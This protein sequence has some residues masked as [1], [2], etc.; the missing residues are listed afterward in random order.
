M[1]SV[2]YFSGKIVRK[3]KEKKDQMAKH[4]KSGAVSGQW[5]AHV[6]KAHKKL[7]AG[8]EYSLLLPKMTKAK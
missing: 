4:S 1:P 8:A 7:P 5:T 3:R 2:G 6:V